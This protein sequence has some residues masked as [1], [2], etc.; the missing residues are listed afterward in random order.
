MNPVIWKSVFDH[1]Q[2]LF[3][4]H[5]LVKSIQNII[6]TVYLQLLRAVY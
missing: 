6:Y 3:P 4:F 1:G 5:F 2:I